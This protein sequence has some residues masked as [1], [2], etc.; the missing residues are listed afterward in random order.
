MR[1]RSVAVRPPEL[2]CDAVRKPVPAG[3][4]IVRWSPAMVASRAM[5]QPAT[6]P[7]DPVPVTRSTLSSMAIVAPGQS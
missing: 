6:S 4:M 1:R 3:A 7:P 5:V 2:H